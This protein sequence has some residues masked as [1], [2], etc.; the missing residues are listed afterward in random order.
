MDG[1]LD[2]ESLVNLP[3][4]SQSTTPHAD[5]LTWKIIYEFAMT[6]LSLPNAEIRLQAHLGN[7]FIDA[8]WQPA[9][10]AVMDAEGDSHAAVIA[11]KPLEQ[12]AMRRLG[13]KIQISLR[14]KELPQL[15]LAEEEL[16]KSI[17]D[18]KARNRIFDTL[19]TLNEVLDPPEEVEIREIEVFSSGEKGE[20][21][22]VDAVHHEMAVARGEVIE[23]DS[24]EEDSP[25]PC[26]TRVQ[27]MALCEELAG[28]VSE[29]GEGDDIFELSKQL[30]RFRGHLRRQEFANAKQ[31]TLDAYIGKG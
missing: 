5:P 21:E 30:C 29:Y 9:L 6:D 19:P 12:A 4:S 8:D 1:G 25:D 28:V 10:R 13:L 3:S 2:S 17:K 27:A 16:I 7:R 22:I 14:P 23:I 31:T 24:D 18:L 11:I 15:K 20:Q 26:I